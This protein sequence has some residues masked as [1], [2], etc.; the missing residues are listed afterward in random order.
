[1]KVL[2]LSTTDLRGG[3]GRSAFHIHRGL[4]EVGVDSTMLVHDRASDLAS[5][6]ATPPPPE[7]EGAWHFIRKVHL[8][9]NRSKLSST[10]FSF[11]LSG[12]DIAAH[13][14]VR[15]ADVLH[16]HWLAGWL[17]PATLAPLL[18]L[19][20][21]VVWTMHDQR[22]FTGGCHFSAGCEKLYYA[23]GLCSP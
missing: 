12:S 5:V 18:A 3:A 22:P 17:P 19:G 2:H 14:A 13:P 9:A 4:L 1:M 23:G 10:Y 16:L 20:K 6:I 8:D 15:S 21:R 11:D 7:P